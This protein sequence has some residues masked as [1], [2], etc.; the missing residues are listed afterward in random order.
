MLGIFDCV[1]HH[2]FMSIP[3]FFSSGLIKPED[4]GFLRE[5]LDVIE[6]KD[7]CELIRVYEDRGT[8][9]IIL[10]NSLQNSCMFPK[11][12]SLALSKR[13]TTVPLCYV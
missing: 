3:F 8:V 7:L 12:D 2:L 13:S 10:Q 11:I 6:R 4:L 9:T 5:L 1:A